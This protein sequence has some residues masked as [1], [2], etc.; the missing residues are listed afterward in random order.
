MSKSGIQVGDL[1]RKIT[2]IQMVG[3]VLAIRYNEQLGEI[4]AL[5]KFGNGIQ[6]LALDQIEKFETEEPDVWSNL[7]ALRFA[8]SQAFRIRMTLERLCSPPSPITSA[9]GT[10]RTRFYP[11]QFKPVLKFLENPQQRALIADDV[12]LGK[13]IEA[14]YILR[15]WR[16]RQSL[17]NILIVVPAR[18]RTKWRGELKARFDENFDIVGAKELR[19]A[20]K[21]T[22]KKKEFPEFNWII[23]FESVRQPDLAALIDD[24]KPS[25]DLLILDE[26]HRVRNRGTLQYKAA[27]ALCEC[28]DAIVFLTA[29]PVQTGIEDLYTLVDLLEP[30]QYG[31]FQEFQQL[32][33]AN[34]PLIRAGRLIARGS[35]REAAMEM[36]SLAGNPLTRPLTEDPYF[37]DVVERLRNAVNRDR[38]YMVRL[39]RDVGEFSLM[40]HLLSRTRK[41]EVMESWPGPEPQNPPILFTEEE[42]AV[43]KAARQVTVLLSKVES[44]W[45]RTMAAMMAYRYTASCIPAAA[46]YFK[47]RLDKEGL[48]PNKAE[49]D[50]ELEIEILEDE[51][52]ADWEDPSQPG[53]AIINQI[54]E[55]LANCPTP[56]TDSKFGAF[57]KA[58]HEIW[59]DDCRHSRTPRK[60]VVFSFFKR[61]LAYLS[62]ELSRL[63]IG[64][65]VIHGGIPLDERDERIEDFLESRNVNVLLSSEVG[66]EGIDLQKASVVVNYDL[67]WNPMVVEQRIG[68]ID[69]IGQKANRLIILN[70]VS[71]DTI[72]E[73]ILFRLYERI[74]LFRES[75]GE[76]DEI[77]GTRDV[78]ELMTEALRGELTPEQLEA[79]LEMT[80]QAAERKK[81][82]GGHLAKQVDGL[83]AADQAFI[84]E[85]R[86]LDKHRRFPNQD[87]IK[88]FLMQ[89]LESR[90]SGVNLVEKDRRPSSLHMGSTA[91]R[92]FA[93]WSRTHSSDGYRTAMKAQQGMLVTFDPEIAMEHPRCEFIQGRHT[94]VQFAVHQLQS[95]L[96]EHSHTFGLSLDSDKVQPGTWAIGIWNVEIRGS[97][98]ENRLE[99][100]ACS[101]DD[102]TILC[103]EQVEDLLLTCMTSSYDL[104]PVP[105]ISPGVLRRCCELLRNTLD[106]RFA[107]I[108][109]E[110][111]AADQR[112]LARLK[113][114]WQQTLANRISA[115]SK[116]YNELIERRA[117]DFAIRMAKDKL[118]KREADL[119]AKQEE[120]KVTTKP[121]LS[122]REIAVVL[123]QVRHPRPLDT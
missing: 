48:F 4:L 106:S 81:L 64:N 17:S 38:A 40:G 111:R 107:Q 15:E 10:A 57:S 5:I 99:A 25:I 34:R 62:R 16:A 73:Q 24:L 70:L 39:Q 93:Q 42:M 33:E 67:P 29:T 21:A 95:G 36:E 78:Q 46:E 72:E 118:A 23:G 91:I 1:I 86:Y 123:A 115:A 47:S 50:S 44:D 105:Q 68:R 90:Y 69:R 55:I 28:A 19:R 35:T 113:A 30:D 82:Q 13:T 110:T 119:I 101:T 66:G 94:L 11:Y 88:E 26:A 20:L 37:K 22:L 84:D 87:D 102:Q 7:V 18:L 41:L 109:Q 76:I 12:G 104:D 3:K 65:L 14:G 120:F 45:G 9:F 31:S 27:N 8:R 56:G 43:Y 121:N 103:G 100:I 92:D 32:I 60:I 53:Q 80:A 97:R 71:H 63:S 98:T 2:D 83:L 116:R 122:F 75:I 61:T 77:L 117:A 6:T 96:T 49:L 79:Q 59:Q 74:G 114:T 108:V 85:I 51:R 54:H 112:R 52:D 89:F 58:L